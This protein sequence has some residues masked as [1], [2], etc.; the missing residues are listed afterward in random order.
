MQTDKV[1][2]EDP[3]TVKLD[4]KTEGGVLL[5]DG[6][7]LIIRTS[8]SPDLVGS[9]AAFHEN[10]RYVFASYLIRLRTDT[11]V[12]DPDHAACVLN[13]HVDRQQRMVTLS[14]CR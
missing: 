2:G 13:S 9:C 1:T 5:K 3:K 4:P 8:G 6:D 14:F 12:A 10:G 11:N 7:V